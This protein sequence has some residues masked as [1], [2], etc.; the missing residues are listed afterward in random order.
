MLSLSSPVICIVGPTA[1]GKSDLAQ[2]VAVALKGEIIS[3]DSMQI[4]RGMDIG[5]AK[6]PLHKR[7]VTHRGIDL[8]DP[9]QPYSAALFQSYAR[10]CFVA[11]DLRCI[12]S[13]LVGGSGF[14]L[15]AAIDDYCFPDGEQVGNE[16]RDFYQNLAQIE[17]SAALWKRLNRQDQASAALIAPADTKRVIRAFELLDAGTSY[18]HQHV[19]L[20]Q[21]PPALDAVFLGLS[22]ETTQLND[23]INQRVDAMIE[24]GL[25]AEVQTLLAQG[26]RKGLTASQAI[27]Y[28]EIVAALEGTISIEVAISQIK[29]ATRR[30][31]KRQRT[32][33]R[34][35]RRIHWLDASTKDS[36]SLLSEA[37]QVI[38][39]SENERS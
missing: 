30:Y 28:K 39:A 7:K 32:W 19:H 22:L 20:S 17:G 8:I 27:G 9:G 13:V 25:V 29:Q 18:A 12:R 6:M 11:N 35:D 14:Y 23:R 24:A 16:V 3:A 33:F 1:S 34:K 4:Y 31:A 10:S 15:R 38:Q 21:I 2:S 5:T 36:D 26:F 37:L